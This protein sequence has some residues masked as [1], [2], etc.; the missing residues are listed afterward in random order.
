MMFT[1]LPENTCEGMP[2]HAVNAGLGTLQPQVQEWVAAQ[3]TLILIYFLF[4]Q[5][6]LFSLN[7]LF[8]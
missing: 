2:P 6:P 5:I 8:F 7:P 1:S 3:L 4:Q